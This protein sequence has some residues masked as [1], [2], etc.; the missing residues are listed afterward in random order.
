MNVEN[1]IMKIVVVMR[2]GFVRWYV[3]ALLLL[4]L[5]SG[6][7]QSVNEDTKLKPKINIIE[8]ENVSSE[9]TLPPDIYVLEKQLTIEQAMQI[10]KLLLIILNFYQI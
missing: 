5:I 9:I 6:C 1:P 10:D 7:S 8:F 3:F 2:L 4:G